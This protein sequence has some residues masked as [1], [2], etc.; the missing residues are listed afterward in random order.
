MK[1]E[2]DYPRA[3]LTAD[4][5]IIRYDEKVDKDQILLIQRNQEPFKG[6]YALPGGFM[7][8]DTDENLEETAI[9]ELKEETGVDVK[10]MH[11]VGT[12]SQI[13]RDPRGRVVSTAYVA[14][15]FGELDFEMDLEE[16]QNIKWFYIDDL[17]DLAFDHSR[18]INDAVEES[19]TMTFNG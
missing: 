15:V 7:E 14:E 5:V 8:V 19:F 11:Q 9:R 4:A 17:P 1:Y 3:S 10:R 6:C 13:G 2:Y 16:I 18:M 12:Y